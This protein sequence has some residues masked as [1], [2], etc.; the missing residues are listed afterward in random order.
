MA[1]PIPDLDTMEAAEVA[2]DDKLI[3]E[4]TSA[5]ETKIIDVGK[6][7][8]LPSVGWTAAGETWSFVSWNSTTKIGVIQV[9]TDATT[10]YAIDNFVRFVQSTGGTKY[11]RILSLTSTQLTV[12]L[13]NYTLNNEAITVPNYSPLA[14]PIG[15]PVRIIK[16]TPY[17]FYAYRTTSQSLPDS[18]VQ[19]IIFATEANDYASA[20]DN[21]TGIFTAPVTGLY[22]IDAL[23]TN[24]GAGTGTNMMWEAYNELLLNNSTVIAKADLNSYDNGY[25]SIVSLPANMEIELTAGDTLRMRS[26]AD[27]ANS[28]PGSIVGGRER[29][30]FEARLI[31]RM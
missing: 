27:T 2:S 11:G 13:P 3:I 28:Q 30:Y 17:R 31:A 20:Y 6:L 12:W 7:L 15:A 29:N 21:S 1:L 19:T 24:Q 14:S 8:G 25:N 26:L 10:K 18:S 9:P 4:D 23:V 22:R 16:D 5:D